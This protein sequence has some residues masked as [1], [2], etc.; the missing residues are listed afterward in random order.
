MTGFAR[1][2]QFKYIGPMALLPA[3]RSGHRDAGSRSRRARNFTAQQAIP[4]PQGES[5]GIAKEI[6]RDL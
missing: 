1:L 3:G 4:E 2:A 5:L 6:N